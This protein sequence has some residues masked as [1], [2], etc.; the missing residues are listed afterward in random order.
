MPAIIQI[1]NL[2]KKYKNAADFSIRDISLKIQEG[3]IFGLLGPNGAG[4]TT[5]ISILCGLLQPTSG[6]YEIAGFS[7]D[8]NLRE[9]QKSSVSFRRIMRFT[10]ALQQR[11]T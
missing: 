3:E 5:L 1:Q 7:P 6:R 10:Q 4:K 11:K 9:I 8:R 2:S